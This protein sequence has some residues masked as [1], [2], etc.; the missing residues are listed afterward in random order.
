M[1]EGTRSGPLTDLTILDCT[2]ALAGPFGSAI[3]ADLGADVI[4][5]G[6]MVNR[7]GGSQPFSPLPSGAL[8][9]V[10]F[11]TWPAEECPLCRDDAPITKPGSRPI[12]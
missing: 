8:L 3:L 4:G 1:T 2:M 5:V 7:S 11:P 6:S 12:R 9:E 10:D